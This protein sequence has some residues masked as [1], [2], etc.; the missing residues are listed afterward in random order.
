MRQSSSLKKAQ[1]LCQILKLI[2]TMILISYNFRFL[3]IIISLFVNLITFSVSFILFLYTQGI[4]QSIYSEHELAW[5]RRY[6]K[7]PEWLAIIR[8]QHYW[9]KRDRH[10]H[11]QQYHYI[12]Q[13]FSSIQKQNSDNSMKSEM[14]PQS[15][16]SFRLM[17]KSLNISM[18]LSINYSHARQNLPS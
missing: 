9:K 7:W 13:S 6:R 16:S 12:N 15:L 3:L 18:N 5:I 14:T 17:T 10:H 4:R 1:V 2:L 8:P 11:H